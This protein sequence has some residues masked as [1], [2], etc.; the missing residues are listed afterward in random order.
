MRSRRYFRAES[1]LFLCLMV[2]L[3]AISPETASA[4]YFL[5]PAGIQKGTGADIYGPGHRYHL[6]APKGWTVDTQAAKA[7]GLGAVFYPNG[8]SWQNAPVV[9]Y[10]RILEHDGKTFSQVIDGDLK[11]MAQDSRTF[12]ATD[13]TAVISTRHQTALVKDLTG[14]PSGQLERVAYFEEKHWVVLIVLVAHNEA[15]LKNSFQ[16]FEQLV[17][18]YRYISDHSDVVK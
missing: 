18:S 10:T 1:S 15:D 11:A 7:D 9:M 4:Q 8:S 14:E 16:A 17:Q 12:R 6:E 2:L 13:K 5:T 3:S